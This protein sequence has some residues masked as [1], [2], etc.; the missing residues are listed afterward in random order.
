V[1]VAQED[2]DRVFRALADPTRRR[3]L[4]RLH[5]RDGQTLGDLCAG[6]GMARQSATQHIGV[7]EAAGLV[8]AVRRGREKL[9][10]LNPVP[11]HDI[12]ER[13]IDPITR[14]RLRTLSDVKRRAEE[15]TA[16]ADAPTYVYV[17]YIHATPE[18]VWEAL[19]DADLTAA[20]WGH[21]T[22]SD[23]QPG[24]PWEHQGVDGLPDAGGTVLEAEPPHRLVLTFGDPGTGPDA[25][26]RVTFLVEG[27]EDIVRLTV[28][29]DGVGD[30]DDRAALEAGWP[31]VCAN[32]KSLLETGH[33]LPQPPWEMQPR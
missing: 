9:H 7:L 10:F 2:A 31:A 18:R 21:R 5:E 24:S 4:D 32:L 22:V 6:L 11:L 13:W 17:T 16:M 33:A 25:A 26:S 30:P 14:P 23:W 3:V 8:T 27:H 20:Y 15:R 12:Q 29:H 19:T 1:P 28:R